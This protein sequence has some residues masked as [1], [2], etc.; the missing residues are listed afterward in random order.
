MRLRTR[1]ANQSAF[2]HFDPVSGVKG[3]KAAGIV[4][5][6]TIDGLPVTAKELSC[7]EI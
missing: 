1:E 2:T 3:G 5:E 4:V 6:L 7:C